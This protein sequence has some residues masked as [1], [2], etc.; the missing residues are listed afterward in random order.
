[1]RVLHAVMA[2][3]VVVLAP[4]A[5]AHEMRSGFLEI[6]E[7]GEG[8]YDVRW[9]MPAV[10]ANAGLELRFAEDV[11]VVGDPVS[12]MLGGSNVTRMQVR[13]PGGLPGGCRP[14]ESGF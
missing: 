10:E 2:M 12:A 13:R 4:W 3:L 11:E 9:R 14:W 5:A 7:T 1:M 6:R 8:A